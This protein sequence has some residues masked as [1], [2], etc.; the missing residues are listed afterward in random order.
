M[1]A[2]KMT[3]KI[4]VMINIMIYI[5]ITN[6]QDNSEHHTLPASTSPQPYLV[7]DTDLCSRAVLSQAV[8]TASGQ[9]AHI[10]GP[11]SRQ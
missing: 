2:M 9:R 11:D 8:E 4:I 5:I 3:N 7:K 6:H 10:P 1:N